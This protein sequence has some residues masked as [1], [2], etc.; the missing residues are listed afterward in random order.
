[1]KAKYNDSLDQVTNRPYL[2]LAFWLLLV[3]V[4][5]WGL[6]N[7]S[8]AA[9]VF[10]WTLFLIPDSAIAAWGD[11]PITLDGMIDRLAVC[12]IAG[13]VL[14]LSG[15]SGW[16][17]IR[18][19]MVRTQLR[20]PETMALAITLGL[21]IHATVVVTIGCFGLLRQTAAVFFVATATLGIGYLLG[22]LIRKWKGFCL[23]DGQDLEGESSKPDATRAG[24][25]DTSAT[26]LERW[27]AT[28]AGSYFAILIIAKAILPPAEYD[29]REYHL[30]APKEWWLTGAIEFMPH[31]IYANMPMAAESHALTSMM[32]WDV[33]GGDAETNAW[34]WGA[35]SGKVIIASF[36]ILLSMLVGG[37]VRMFVQSQGLP[38]RLSLMASRWSRVMVLAFPAVIEGAA[39]GLIEVAVACYFA[40]GL[41]VMALRLGVSNA[42]FE[43]RSLQEITL[44]VALAAGGA[45]G[46][47]YPAVL[48]ILPP[49][50][51]VWIWALSWSKQQ[52]GGHLRNIFRWDLITI[53]IS[54]IGLG[55]GIWYLKN[56]ILTGNP[57]YPLAGN[58]F[59]GETL[60]ADK[61]AQWNA[62]HTVPAYS[63]A[64]LGD[65]MLDLL[66]RWRLQGW[67]LVPFMLLGLFAKER[68]GTVLLLLMA[69][70][71]FLAWW[72]ATHRVDRFL[73]PAL[74]IAFTLA[75]VGIAIAIQRF[76]GRVGLGVL[77]LCLLMNA[78]YASGPV[79]G[80][81]RILVALD[82]LRKD[83]L[84]ESSV[85]RLPE[86]IR[87]ANQNLRPQDTILVVGDA[88]VFD[89]EVPISYSTTFDQSK[90]IDLTT[91][92]DATWPE[93][94]SGSGFRYVLVHWGEV[95]RLRST[96]GFDERISRALFDKLVTNGIVTRVETGDESGRYELYR[97]IE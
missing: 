78:V 24:Q 40:A 92:P 36:A 18:D 8:V 16:F 85:T 58:V 96:Y 2:S 3:I 28:V 49:L 79:L 6:L 42:V 74:P 10:R 21:A 69:L 65:S 7:Q 35:L 76:G 64:T 89:F 43:S 48:L 67:C 37:C 33:V 90:L 95:E 51:G 38:V 45:I 63:L 30:Q 11:G 71:A 32:I 82:Y 75:G 87:W 12:C 17:L 52:E 23:D 46:C 77:G 13:A 53:W 81:G 61:I 73:I 31:N 86:H 59:G 83:N 91:E 5:G 94:F 25:P 44:L 1:M 50:V 55:G 93:R 57:V 26:G 70:Y 47:K 4:W 56:A 29:V 9:G 80:D 62:G 68:R 66:W 14:G 41:M 34:W 54:M 84:S 22:R 88:A 97:V 15:L 60:T 19:G 72:L 27:V 20:F 39:L